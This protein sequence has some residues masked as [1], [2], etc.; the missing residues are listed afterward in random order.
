[1]ANKTR[2]DIIAQ[3][4][5]YVPQLNA[6]SHDTLIDNVIDLAA[7]EISYRHNFNFLSEST[8]I[9]VS[10]SEGDYSITKTTFGFTDFKEII[11]M[12]WLIST[13]GSNAKIMYKPRKRFLLDY[14]YIDYSGITG[15]KPTFYTW[16]ENTVFF[17]C[18]ADED[19]TIR[20]WYQKTHGNFTD[21]STSHLFEPDNLGFQAIIAVALSEIQEALPGM[22]ISQKTALVMQKKEYWINQLIEID[23]TKADQEI[24][25]GENIDLKTSAGITDPYAWV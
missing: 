18:P 5:W 25:M 24:E 10:L 8:P 22:E 17:N 2:A 23:M 11:H 9:D 15:G 12:L 6:E 14:P 3:L 21:D 16:I 7:E 19:I 20:V 1:M 4:K 13:T